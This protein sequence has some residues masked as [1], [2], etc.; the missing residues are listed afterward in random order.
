MDSFEQARRHFL[1]G[2]SRLGSGDPVAAEGHFRAS[3]ACLPDRPSTLINLAAALLQ[4]GRLAEAR[5]AAARAT[6]VDPSAADGWLNLGLV[7]LAEGA[8]TEAL[9]HA[10]RLLAVDPRHPGALALGAHALE[11]TGDL[12]AAAERWRQLL[13]VRPDD[14]AA[15]A[16][17]GSTLL[18]LGRLDEA[19]EASAR[20][21]G[22]APAHP[23]VLSQR[24][25]V[26]ER[27]G[28]FDDA[29]AALQAARDRGAETDVALPLA[30]LLARVGRQGEALAELDSRLAAAPRD[31]AAW[32]ERAVLLQTLGRSDEALAS[33]DRALALE[34]GDASVWSAKGVVLGRQRRH[35]EALDCH[36]RA[37]ALAPEAPEAWSNKGTALHAL[38]RFEEAL[39]DLD[40]AIRLRPGYAEALTSRGA[41]LQGLRRFEAALV[42]HDEALRLAPEYALAW[43]N[44]ALT[45]NALGRP[46]EALASVG[47]A[48]ELAPADH[49]A[50]VARVALLCGLDRAQD[51]LPDLEQ[52]VRL[53]P[54]DPEKRMDLSQLRLQ[55]LDFARGWSDYEARFRTKAY[56][57]TPPV[58]SRPRW[59]G[60]RSASRL[61]IWGEQGLGDQILHGS[62]L[63]DAARLPQPV[64][65]ALDARLVPLFQRSFPTLQVRAGF[66]GVAES[67]HDE[68]VPIGSLGR[69]FR[70]SVEEFAAA[71]AG[72]L[73]PDAGRVAA[74]RRDPAWPGGLRV[75]I[76]WRSANPRIGENKSLGLETLAAAL[77][78]DGVH[79]IDL[80][81]GSTLE[82]LERCR[83][84]TGVDVRRVP[85]IDLR[86][87]LEGVAAILAACDRVVTISNTVAHMAGAIGRPT[88]LLLPRVT[89]RI[90]YWTEVEGR[91]LWYPSVRIL[92]QD[93]QGDW[94]GPL[95]R[96]RALLREEAR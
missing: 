55:C 32:V 75:G 62:M 27:A 24:A 46:D 84:A 4:Q 83:E 78:G 88:L 92:R 6:E 7:A 2:L 54:T 47:R 72:W 66:E 91:S 68:Q 79:L 38:R 10:A 19:L 29:I 82:E 51:A 64:T 22:C 42:D 23:R 80:Q 26:L 40:E 96:A 13:D 11:V 93:E 37:V 36:L 65:V 12:P 14:P 21:V 61:L 35:E 50:R 70:R 17:L 58:S 94:G 90:W 56:D 95:A 86:D 5:K 43:S 1:D 60:H 49:A 71:R 87:D 25:A 15:L 18:A 39:T 45:L 67:D 73:Q 8:G 30:R 9:G 34:A 85:G 59:D 77:G 48:I 3:L 69:V 89:G 74:V 57:S 20:A 41:A 16:G 31:R 33:C 44:R 52:A 76:S 53:D 81:Y 63:Q 28:R